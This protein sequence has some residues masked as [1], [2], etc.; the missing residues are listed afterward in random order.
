MY[1]RTS[2]DDDDEAAYAEL[3]DE[4]EA[5]NA[6]VDA[7]PDEEIAI[8]C[9]VVMMLVGVDRYLAEAAGEDPP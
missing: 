9:A 6:A 5:I 3:A 2:D 8:R 7:I 4:I 1:V